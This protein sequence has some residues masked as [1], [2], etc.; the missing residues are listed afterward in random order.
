[1]TLG[2]LRPF[3][4][5]QSTGT[6]GGVELRYSQ[7]L[8]PLLLRDIRLG[9]RLY[10]IASLPAGGVLEERPECVIGCHSLVRETDGVNWGSVFLTDGYSGH[11]GDE[12]GRV[13]SELH[14][15]G[16]GGARAW[17]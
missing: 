9:Q 4:G 15:C 17:P 12:N 10:L 14:G 16:L 2:G 13:A 8:F 3:D 11:D 6:D 7:Q 1:M 5:H